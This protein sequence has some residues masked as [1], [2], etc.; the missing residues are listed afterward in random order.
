MLTYNAICRY[1]YYS[2]NRPLTVSM[3]ERGDIARWQECHRST[4]LTDRLKGSSTSAYLGHN[5]QRSSARA[6]HRGVLTG[7]RAAIPCIPSPRHLAFVRAEQLSPPDS[8]STTFTH[9]KHACHS[10]GA[11]LLARNLDNR[12]NITD[13]TC[14]MQ[15]QGVLWQLAIAL[16]LLQQFML[17][18]TALQAPV[19]RSA[20]RE[21]LRDSLTHSV[22]AADPDAIDDASLLVHTPFNSEASLQVAARQRLFDYGMEQGLILLDMAVRKIGIPEYKTTLD[23]PIIG[24]VD[25]DISDVNITQLVVPPEL[26][27]L[28]IE[29]GYYHL[30][31]ANLTAQVGG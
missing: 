9:T 20:L 29:S 23:L 8:T 3:A 11:L 12:S 15:R 2:N 27:K 19:P 25:V 22:A 21:Q 28:A 31:A 7:I 1:T 16:L 13:H 5:T 24:G 6:K 18:C 30:T 26:T 4:H 10:P 17:A 14:S